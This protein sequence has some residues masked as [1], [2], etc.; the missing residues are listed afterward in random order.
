L[1]L[2]KP[3]A[4]SGCRIGIITALLSAALAGAPARLARGNTDE[5]NRP[6]GFRGEISG[7]KIVEHAPRQKIALLAEAAGPADS[8][9]LE[10]MAQEAMHY[11][12]HNPLAGNDHECRFDI[13]LLKFPPS[14]YPGTRDP[15]IT[16]G[17]T[18]ARMALAFPDLRE[19]T[20]SRE[21]C[22]VE[23]AIRRR[24]LGY[25]RDD[26][27]AWLPPYALTC[28]LSDH[29]PC[30]SNWTTDKAISIL[31]GSYLRGGNRADLDRARK[32]ILGLRS[33]ARWDGG[34]AYYPGGMGGWRDGKWL[35]TGCSNLYPCI[36]DPIAG[37]LEARP[38]KEIMDF[39]VAFAEGIIAG[40]Q[41]NL[42]TNRIREDGSFGGAN[43]HLHMRAAYGVA[44]LGA[45][46]KNARYLEWA[47]K[48]YDWLMT[49]GTDWGWFPESPGTS[50]SETC[51]TG[52]MVAMAACLA[53]AGHTRYWDDVERFVRNYC[54]E[55]QFFP[56]PE[57][58]ALYRSQ[59]PGASESA[60]GIRQ[61]RDF[62]GGFVARLTPNSLTMDDR[63]SMM[64]CCPPEAMRAL[65][66]AWRN[67]VTKNA[68]GVFVNLGFDRE[69]AQARVVS[70]APSTG[71]LTV[72]ARKP[73][74]F[75]LR[76]PAW[77]ARDEVRAFRGTD[78]VRTVWKGDYVA[79]D[80][81]KPG[82]QLT[83]AWPLIGFKQTV[84]AGGAKFSYDWLGN[85]VLGVDPPG[86]GFPLFIRWA[87]RGSGRE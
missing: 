5:A 1:K 35:F 17:D 63:M 3:S 42:G 8:V 34:R 56:T 80:G 69:S 36:L 71:R 21:G 54:R 19:M 7:V 46:T 83:A 38:D 85:T 62:K 72:V 37:Y 81:V 25:I 33:L 28:D 59:H 39:A 67:I 41:G 73:A 45:L 10:R 55:A 49:Q 29:R 43:S 60:E 65:A 58:E 14:M 48:V 15:Y 32:L 87:K 44:R 23:D 50:N 82:E 75:Y 51:A 13:D 20:G 2:I 26:G 61:A 11:L 30:A 74:T 86:K 22:E 47:G 66:V 6:L 76:P 4:A 24:V 9:S 31:V 27:L 53:G 12:T 16:F 18:E 78:R 84:T 57:Y 52:D 64:G 68:D 77:A 79:F 70:F 40:L